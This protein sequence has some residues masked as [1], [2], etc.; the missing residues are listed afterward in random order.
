MVKQPVPKQTRHDH[1]QYSTSEIHKSARRHINHNQVGK[2]IQKGSAEIFGCY[3]HQN[4]NSRKNA[5]HHDL[6]K[7]LA[8]VQ[9]GCNKHDKNNF[10]KLRRLDGQRTDRQGQF[11]PIAC[12]SGNRNNAQCT[13]TYDH[14]HPCQFTEQR[15]ILQDHGN[16]Q[17][18][19]KTRA[20]KD[21]LPEC[22]F[23]RNTCQDNKS[24]RK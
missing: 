1:C 7:I 3:Q 5:C 19:H 13:D 2:K 14:I 9:H 10:Y 12:L 21:K 17:G 6:M 23:K 24:N 18:N 16:Q 20:H 8:L 22:L 11:G 4:K 15:H